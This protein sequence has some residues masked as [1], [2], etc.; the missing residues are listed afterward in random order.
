MR[1]LNIR[2]GLGNI[3]DVAA[4]LVTIATVFASL[5]WISS[6]KA[7]GQAGDLKTAALGFMMLRL[8]AATQAS[9][10]LV[11]AQSYLT[12][13]GMYYAEADTTNNEELKTYLN[14]LGDQSMELSNF[15]TSVTK[16]AEQKS[17]GYF[18]KYTEVLETSA[19]FGRIADYR[20]TAALILNVSAAAASGVVLF[21][22]RFLLY[23]FAP[24][25]LLGISYLVASLF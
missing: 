18:D 9:N 5:S 20:S 8:E 11:Q 12:Q 16:E 17:Q 25:F 6:G 23:V 4:I 7:G 21:K 15:Q 19:Q 1:Q 10:A 3:A 14:G 24:V 13:A 22:K 2:F